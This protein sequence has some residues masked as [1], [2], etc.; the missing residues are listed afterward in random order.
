MPRLVHTRLNPNSPRWAQVRPF[1][2]RF[3]LYLIAIAV[4]LI[5]ILRSLDTV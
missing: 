3:L 4:A 5:V 1:A 2:V